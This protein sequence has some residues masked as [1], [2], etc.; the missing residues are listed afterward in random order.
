MEYLYKEKLIEK[1]EII[2]FILQI[3]FQEWDWHLFD[4]WPDQLIMQ[5]KKNVI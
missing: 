3:L 1:G 5:V 2:L 4:I